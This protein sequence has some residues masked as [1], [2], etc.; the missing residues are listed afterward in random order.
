MATEPSVTILVWTCWMAQVI[1]V[2]TRYLTK[3]LPYCQLFLAGPNRVLQDPQRKISIPYSEADS[4]AGSD[5]SEDH[6]EVENE[7][8][9]IKPDMLAIS[10]LLNFDEERQKRMNECGSARNNLI[11]IVFRR[12]KMT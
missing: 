2:K 8:K 12:R 9:L 4:G 1:S 10:Q 6:E 5:C 11:L 7:R 3:T